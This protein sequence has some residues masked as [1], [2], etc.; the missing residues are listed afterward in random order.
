M[1]NYLVDWLSLLLRWLHLIAGIAWIGAS[2]YF[3]WLDNHLRPP[4][5]PGLAAKGVSGELWAIHGGGFY[6]PQKYL[7][8]PP[9]LP[10]ELHW[11]KWEAY[12]TWLSGVALLTATYFFHADTY[13]IDSAVMDL[14]VPTAIL[15]ALGTLAVGW[16]VYDGLCKT[17]LGNKDGWLGVA[18]FILTVA[19][20]WGL[21]HIFAARAAYLLTGATLATI[22]AANVAM[23]IIPGQRRM[24]EAMQRGEMP[25][26]RYGHWGKQRSV[27]NNYFTLPVLFAMISSHYAFTYDHAYGWAI[28]AAIMAAGA[29]IRHFFNLRHTGQVR[30]G[31]P[32]A[33]AAILAAVAA[34]IAPPHSA[35]ATA[36]SSSQIDTFRV[37]AVIAERCAVCHAAKPT[38]PGFAS[39]PAGIRLD[40]PARIRAA[41]AQIY[42]QAAVTKAMPLGNA[43]SI[44]DD[45]R[46]LIAAWWAAG[47]PL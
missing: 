29:L 41:A 23:V 26:P 9:Q 7:V 34:I 30:W 31:F 43:T 25:D 8:A 42:Q 45:E 46:K 10:A 11:F 16:L 5:D 19:L 33:G 38:Y 47:A 13:L 20:A 14:S 24:V 6:N 28:L 40:D 12:T 27:H 4:A 1:E 17:P 32:L 37:R 18:L 44:T 2:F 35:P 15:I 36:A 3:V 21:S 39:P 22:M